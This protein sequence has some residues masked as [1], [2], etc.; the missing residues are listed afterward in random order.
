MLS[1]DC[2]KTG[3]V[4]IPLHQW[5]AD[6]ER[7]NEEKPMSNDPIG[8]N[9]EHPRRTYCSFLSAR[10]HLWRLAVFPSHFV[11]GVH[12]FTPRLSFILLKS[13]TLSKNSVSY[14]EFSMKSL[15]SRLSLHIWSDAFLRFDRTTEDLLENIPQTLNIT[16][17]S[18]LKINTRKCKLFK[19]R[20]TSVKASLFQKEFVSIHGAMRHS[21]PC[22][23]RWWL[24]L[25]EAR[26]RRQLD[27]TYNST[28]FRTYF[29]SPQPFEPWV[30]NT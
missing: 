20:H 24:A 6:L 9:N 23:P 13:S 12:V 27:A 25:Y 10:F 1:V 17:Q 8:S 3:S 18:G 19:K 14:F 15:F 26:A 30:H 16:L 5:C 29:I 22:L 11:T 2:S 4:W 21:P 7:W 28:L